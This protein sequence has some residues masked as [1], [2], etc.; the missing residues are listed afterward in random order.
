MTKTVWQNPFGGKVRKLS[1]ITGLRTH[2]R[3][4]L[5]LRDEAVGL[6]G[7]GSLSCDVRPGDLVTGDL[8]RGSGYGYHP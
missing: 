8:L 1:S 3:E 6:V 7:F 4:D 2:W 5:R